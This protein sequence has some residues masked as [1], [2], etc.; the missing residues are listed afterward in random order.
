M[1]IIN[2]SGGLQTF[3]LY[4]DSM[5]PYIENHAQAPQYENT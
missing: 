3:W 4:V 5:I 2:A 1:Y